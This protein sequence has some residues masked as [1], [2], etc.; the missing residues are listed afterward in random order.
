M[1][2]QYTLPTEPVED[3]VEEQ[4]AVFFGRFL[5]VLHSTVFLPIS[6]PWG[7]TEHYAKMPLKRSCLFSV[8]TFL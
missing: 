8:L 5:F 3:A 4:S 1:Q 2:Q 7:L 6:F